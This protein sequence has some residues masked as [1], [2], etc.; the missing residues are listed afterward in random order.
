[1]VERL[2]GLEGLNMLREASRQVC[3]QGAEEVA[4]RSLV[5]VDVLKAEQFGGVG[6]VVRRRCDDVDVL[7]SWE[8]CGS[9]S[10]PV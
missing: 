2:E 10:A 8:V 7:K 3:P 5:D 6:V 9:T 4:C 1:M